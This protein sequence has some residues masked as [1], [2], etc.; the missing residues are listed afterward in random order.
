M[1][2][3]AKQA[4]KILSRFKGLEQQLQPGE[5]PRLTV[6][7]IWDGGNQER[8][9]PCEVI[10]TNQRLIGFYFRSFPREKL[11]FDAL[12]L[13]NI[14]GI[15]VRQKSY[16]PVFRELMVT[17]GKRKIYVRAPKRKI[18]QLYNALR[19]TTSVTDR[20]ATPE[21]QI[22]PS[23]T[24][25]RQAM[26]TSFESSSLAIMLL[27]IIGILLEVIGLMIWNTNGVGT[28]GPLCFAGLI[29]VGTAIL[30]YRQRNK[31]KESI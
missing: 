16:E 29:S 27:F 9:E 28:G 13:S 20:P 10:I 21:K 23:P 17:E 24:Y 22:D 31:R 12:T 30:L 19:K 3:H 1:S 15:T 11:F 18:E 25:E 2:E 7:A 26:R 8:G 4:V 6:P 5:E 14:N